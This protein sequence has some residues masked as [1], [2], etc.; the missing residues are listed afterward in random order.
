MWLGP[1]SSKCLL[2]RGS[3]STNLA[4]PSRDHPWILWLLIPYVQS[5]KFFFSGRLLKDW[6]ALSQQ[7]TLDE[8]DYLNSFQLG[9]RRGYWSKDSIGG[10][11]WMIFGELKM[12]GVQSVHPGCLGLWLAVW[13]HHLCYI[14]GPA[15]EARSG[16]RVLLWFTSFLHGWYQSVLVGEERSSPRLL[17]ME[18]LKAQG[19]FP[20]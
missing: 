18:C 7:R 2:A 3:G 19:S 1:S 14:A 20:S 9:F 4:P 13:C 8:A 11:L 5:P 17:Y 6:W 15:S 16:S 10:S 12:L